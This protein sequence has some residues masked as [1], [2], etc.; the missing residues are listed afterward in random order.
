MTIYYTWKMGKRNGTLRCQR[1]FGDDT[2]STFEKCKVSA[3]YQSQLLQAGELN[4]T[5][6]ALCRDGFF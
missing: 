5:Q 6:T 2:F 4:R 1:L 3:E